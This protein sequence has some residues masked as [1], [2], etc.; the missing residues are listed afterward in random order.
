MLHGPHKLDLDV[1]CGQDETTIGKEA[2]GKDLY[3][4][5]FSYQP[6]SEYLIVRCA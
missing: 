4:V 1:A 5:T 6:G 3:R 2:P